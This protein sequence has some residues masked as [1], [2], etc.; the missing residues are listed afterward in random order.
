[1]EPLFE[2]KATVNEIL[3]AYNIYRIDQEN[4]KAEIVKDEDSDYNTSAPEELTLTKNHGTW[5]TH[6]NNNID[7]VAT[8]GI[9]IDV[10]NNGYGALLGRIGVR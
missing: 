3:T 7:L 2:A 8:L 10:F 4:Y 1:M 5:T 9:E 6:D